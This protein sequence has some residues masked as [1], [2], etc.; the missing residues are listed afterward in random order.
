MSLIAVIGERCTTTAVGV[1]SAWPDPTVDPVVV[2]LDPTGGDLAA[3]LGLLRSPSLSDV[4]AGQHWTAES[5]VIRHVQ[6]ALSGLDVLVAPTRAIESAAAVSAAGPLLGTLA[7]SSRPYVADLGRFPAS[8]PAAVVGADVVV[9]SHLQHHGSAA[10]A[11]L[12]LERLAERCEAIQR[13][14][15]PLIVAVHG[16]WPYQ[17]DEIGT[18]LGNDVRRPQRPSTHNIP[19]VVVAD[20]SVSAAVVAGRP[21]SARR[22]A[23]SRW[24]SSM[25]AVA[26]LADERIAAR[27]GTRQPAELG[28]V[29]GR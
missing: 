23:R 27:R 26:T 18:Y 20:D 15:L 12:G 8:L 16:A 10:A 14:S 6:P 2:E 5:A 13:R 11:A 25:I 28:Q 22:L 24:M 3:W 17:P 4:V 1:A 7:A 21:G 29:G 9:V 19:I